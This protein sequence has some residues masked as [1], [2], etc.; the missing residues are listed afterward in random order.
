MTNHGARQVYRWPW[1]LLAAVVL[2]FVLAFW[3]MSREVQR[4][5]RIRDLNTPEATNAPAAALIRPVTLMSE[6]DFRT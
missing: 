5:R 6:A 1:F 3:W 4:T 2:A